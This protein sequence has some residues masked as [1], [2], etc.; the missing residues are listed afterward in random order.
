MKPPFSLRIFVLFY[1]RRM[2]FI[3][4]P[5][6][7]LLLLLLFFLRLCAATDV[8][9]T[10]PYYTSIIY[11]NTDK[12]VNFSVRRCFHKLFSLVILSKSF[13]IL[14]V[15]IKT[16]Y[17]IIPKCNWDYISIILLEDCINSS[18]TEKLISKLP[19]APIFVGNFRNLKLP[20]NFEFLY[21]VYQHTFRAHI[22]F[23]KFGRDFSA[24]TF[25]QKC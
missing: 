15:P 8:P 11:R 24:F 12:I 20:P 1:A 9:L 21:A 17:S 7:S 22:D 19:T 13:K 25:V 5:L 18:V 3:K 23:K 4:R 10:Q 2:P 14:L 16:F 6:C